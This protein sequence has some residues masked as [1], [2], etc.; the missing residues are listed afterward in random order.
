MKISVQD[1]VEKKASAE[2]LNLY[3]YFNL[4]QVDWSGKKI[5]IN[6]EEYYESILW[7]FENFR[8]PN[9]QIKFVDS[10]GD[11]RKV[12]YNDRGLEVKFEDSNG[13][14]YRREYNDAGLESNMKPK[15]YSYKEYNDA[16]LEIKYENSWGHWHKKEYNDAG[17]EIKQE[18]SKGHWHKKNTM[19][20][21]SKSNM[22]ILMDI[23]IKGIQ[24]RWTRG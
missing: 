15:M 4:D 18:D 12:E 14:W 20:L 6:D 11:W 24:R 8:I 5:T 16:G 13:Y 10:D 3:K 2:C 23:G 1:L 9:L 21:V 17:L 22:K 7:L 19:M